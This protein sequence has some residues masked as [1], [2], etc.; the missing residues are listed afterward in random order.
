MARSLRLHGHAVVHRVGHLAGHKPAPD[1]P[2][3]PVLVRRQVLFHLL[4]GQ[5]H[6][7]G[8]DG[9]V[10]VLGPGLGLVDPGGGGAVAPAV[11]ALDEAP[12]GGKGLVAQAQGVGTHVGNQAHRALPGDV[13]ALIELLGNGHGPPGG[14]AQLPAGLLLEGRG[15]EGGRG[16][17]LLVLPLDGLDG[18]GGVLHRLHHSLH[19][20]DG[21]QVLFFAVFAVVVGEKGVFLRAVRG[22]PR[23]Q[24]P[25]LLGLEGGDLMLPLTDHPGGHGL[26][27]PGGEAPADLLP[28]QGG[29]LIAHDP[30]QNAP[31]LLGVHQA[32]VNVPG[33]GDGLADHPLGDLVEGD[34]EGL[35]VVQIQKLLQMPADGLPLPVRVRGQIDHVAALGGLLQV[36]DNVLFALDRAVVGLEIVL[37]V[38]AQG[39]LGQV[40]QVAHAGLH[41][42][43]GTQIFTNGLCLGGRLHDHETRCCH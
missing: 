7:A 8:T 15:G 22:Q 42:I 37:N 26:D 33:R 13:H 10:G 30:V 35:A 18:K 39:A 27:P 29:E 5:V 21:V 41:L 43:A 38:H 4:R 31:G 1:E 25:V 14:H 24:R 2:V 3:E 12:H 36:A 16:G 6:V 11:A 19:L 34:P 20:L 32:L 17:A 9:L 23:V 28:Q 40:P